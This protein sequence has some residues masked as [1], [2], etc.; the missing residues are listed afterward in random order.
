[1]K[2][3]TYKGHLITYK[4]GFYFTLGKCFTTI[5]KAKSEIYKLYL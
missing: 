2:K 3:E 4:C 5:K 1:M